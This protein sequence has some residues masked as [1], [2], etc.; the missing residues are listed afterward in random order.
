MKFSNV[1]L[2]MG[3]ISAGISPERV[4]SK[5]TVLQEQIYPV[6]VPHG[7]QFLTENLPLH[8]V[9]MNCL[10]DI[11]SGMI[12]HG[13]QENSLLHHGLLLGLEGNVCFY[14]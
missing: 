3:Y 5:R 7:P 8:R 1:V 2:S 14:A 4:I 9:S 10:A 11:C 12:I 6:W 13:L